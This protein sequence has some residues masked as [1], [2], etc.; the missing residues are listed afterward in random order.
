[1]GGNLLGWNSNSWDGNRGMLLAPRGSTLL[2]YMVL[3]ITTCYVDVRMWRTI[4]VVKT[5]DVFLFIV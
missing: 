3:R 2:L 1:M 4:V 5:H